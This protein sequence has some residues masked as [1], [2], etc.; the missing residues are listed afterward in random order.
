MPPP[1]RVSK[2]SKSWW[3]PRMPEEKPGLPQFLIQ[4]KFANDAPIHTWTESRSSLACIGY[5]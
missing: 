2:S 1:Y 5:E 3:R 4:V